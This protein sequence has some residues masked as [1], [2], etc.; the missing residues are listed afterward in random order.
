MA[1]ARVEVTVDLSQALAGTG[2]LQQGLGGPPQLLVMLGEYLLRSTKDRFKSQ[3]SPEGQPWQALSPRYLKRKRKNKDKI[4]TRDGFLQQQ[5]AYQ[6]DGGDAVLVGSS[7]KYAAIHQFGGKIDQPARQTE[8]FFQRNEKTNQVG[9]LFVK[10]SKSNF[11]Q[12]AQVGPYK[13]TIPARPFLGVSDTDR[14][15][16][17]DITMDFVNTLLE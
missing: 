1:G 7:R 10:K 14:S 3:T 17:V 11:A 12:Q 4:L 8:V 9:R 13:V 6:L 16:L 2:R 5:M 15:E